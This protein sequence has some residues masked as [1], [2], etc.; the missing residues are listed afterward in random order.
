MASIAKLGKGWRAQVAI[1]DVRE[2]KVFATKAEA[3]SWAAR[4]ETEIRDGAATGVQ[5]G[6]TL[7]D[8]FRRYEK[9]VSAHKRGHRQE[10]LRMAAIG[11][12]VIGGVALQDMKLVDITPDVLGKWRDHRYGRQGAWVIGQSRPKS[13]FTRIR[14]GLEGMEVD[15]PLADDRG[16]SP[17]L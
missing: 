1:K 16:V 12:T 6:K 8:A 15:R 17:G 11:R 5:K 2:S 10:V 14:F 7:D 4:R 3:V 13:A 9:E